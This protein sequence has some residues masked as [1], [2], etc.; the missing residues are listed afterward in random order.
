MFKEK[1]KKSGARNFL[2][3]FVIML[4][5][6]GLLL[7]VPG[8]YIPWYAITGF[9]LVPIIL[10]GNQKMRI[11]AAIGF[12]IIFVL[13]LIDHSRGKVENKRVREAFLKIK[14]MHYSKQIKELEEKLKIHNE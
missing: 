4:L 11:Y 10:L 1:D 14:D 6:S 13:I 2:A 5:M 9:L 12:I 3:L 8:N 7:H